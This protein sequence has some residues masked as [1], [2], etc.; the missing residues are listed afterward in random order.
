MTGVHL[1][2]FVSWCKNFWLYTRQQEF[3]WVIPCRTHARIVMLK[4]P[5]FVSKAGHF[6]LI[7]LSVTIIAEN[8]TSKKSSVWFYW[9][10][11]GNR[12]VL[13]NS[14]MNTICLQYFAMADNSMWLIFIWLWRLVQWTVHKKRL[15]PVQLAGTYPT[16]LD[17]FDFVGLDAWSKFGSHQLVFFVELFILSH[18]EGVV[19]MTGRRD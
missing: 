19:L 17:R 5:L 1:L 10:S 16:N 13:R 2:W 9:E 6:H 15:K 12:W 18:M 7:S 8:Q 11:F 14:L 4:V 3:S